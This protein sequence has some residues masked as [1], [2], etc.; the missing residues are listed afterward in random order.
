MWLAYTN[1]D[2]PALFAAVVCSA[3]MGISLY[4]IV[5]A[6]EKRIIFWK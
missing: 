3:L 4:G 1:L 5:V 6:L 2:M